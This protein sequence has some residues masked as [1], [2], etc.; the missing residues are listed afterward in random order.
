MRKPPHD[1]RIYLAHDLYNSSVC[2]TDGGVLMHR[3]KQHLLLLAL[4]V[5]A[6]L[7]HAAPAVL[8]GSG[9]PTGAA[10][11]PTAAAPSL[12]SKERF[13]DLPNFA[14]E[15]PA[16][17]ANKK[18]F[19]SEFELTQFIHRKIAGSP[20][21]SWRRLG[22]TAG[23]RDM[24]L[25]VLTQDGRSDPLSVAA[26]RKPNVWI[27]AQQHGNEPAGAEA[28]LEILRRLVST[29]LRQVLERVN[30]MVVP[31]A[32]PDGA[33]TSQR[34]TAN[35]S[36]MNRDHLAHAVHETQKLHAALNDYPPTVVVDAHEFTVAGRWVDRYGVAEA[37]DVLVQSASHPGVSEHLKRLAKEVFDPALHAAWAQYGLKHFTYHT[38]NVQGPQ[39]FVQMGGNFAGIGRNALGLM[40]AVS[41][42]IESRG[43]GIG[44]DNYPRRVAS[45]V[46]SMT[47]ILKTAAANVDLLRSAQRDARRHQTIGSDWIVDHTAL[48]ESKQM[49][50]LDM[51]TGEDK[52]I[53]VDFQN[54][55]SIT[56]TVLRAL[57]MA[58][59]LPPSLASAALIAKL[60]SHNLNVSRV[61][62]AQELEFESFTVS[63]L[64]QEPGEFGA[65]V[66]RVI[67]ETK[68]FKKTIET[69]SLWVGVTQGY[70]PQWRIA[71]ALFEPESAGSLVGTKWLGSEPVVGQVLPVLRVV[72]GGTVVAPQYE[73]LD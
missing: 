43:V 26:N 24:H 22:R 64:K 10:V 7:G 70:Q 23:G 53:T 71:A 61:G 57:P 51:A 49:P 52:A 63:Q 31:R 29:D 12:M 4:T 55:L 48:R 66:E 54:S 45:H 58:Y 36:D 56:P 65:P 38:L 3:F 1:E 50:M 30:V 73:A 34:E 33:A 21:V 25:L 5:Y 27:I 16:F 68:R 8:P 62:V 15:T 67:T 69:G 46:V 59:V 37:S 2:L 20:H 28:A 13:G 11:A 72:G 44:K 47:S 18:D 9:T 42:L 39:S 41:Y 40:G 17:A 19:T 14:L 35:K 6:C 32:N 60:Q